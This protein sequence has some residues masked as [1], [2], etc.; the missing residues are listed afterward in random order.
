MGILGYVG[1]FL[2]A[3]PATYTRVYPVYPGVP[4]Y[5]GPGIRIYRAGYAQVYSGGPRYTRVFPGTL[6][7]CRRS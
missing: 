7:L 2:G 6:E 1:V 4:G 3:L 5:T